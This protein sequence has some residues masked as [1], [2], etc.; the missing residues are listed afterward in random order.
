[1]MCML[2][3]PLI[4]KVSRGRFT[5]GGGGGGGEEGGG[6][7]GVRRPRPLFEV[8]FHLPNNQ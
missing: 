1:M 3:R 4:L 2:G 6:V 7:Q 8:K 5:G